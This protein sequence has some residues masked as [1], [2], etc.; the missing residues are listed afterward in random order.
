MLM[1]VEG[2]GP[3]KAHDL[4]AAVVKSDKPCDVLRAVNG[5]SGQGLKN[6]ANT[7]ETLSGSA[8]LKPAEQ[9]NH[10]YEYYLPILKEQYDDYPKRIERFGA[11]PYDCR[12]LSRCE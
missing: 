10:V 3:K 11:S 1:L 12:R 8:D 5:R 9:V 7:L 2:V 4:L 6:L